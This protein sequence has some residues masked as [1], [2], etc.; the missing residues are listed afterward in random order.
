MRLFK[1]FFY[2]FKLLEYFYRFISSLNFQIIIGKGI[3][4]NKNIM[5][6]QLDLSSPNSYQPRE[7]ITNKNNT[8]I[9]D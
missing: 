5:N 3:Q 4:I 6:L 2:T 9:R 8:N 7:V 1:V